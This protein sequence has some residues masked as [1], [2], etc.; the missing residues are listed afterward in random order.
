M[1]DFIVKYW[2]EFLFGLIISGMGVMA[3]LMYNQHLKNKAID[4]GVEA[5]LRNGIVQTYNKWSERGYCPIY[6]RENAT[7]MYEPYHILGGNDVAYFDFFSFCALFINPP[8][9]APRIPICVAQYSYT[10]S[11]IAEY[12]RSCDIRIFRTSFPFSLS[13]A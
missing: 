3:K 5:L 1:I 11:F 7:R 13:A 8:I 6:A 4:K 9:Y 10:L 12:L 2:I